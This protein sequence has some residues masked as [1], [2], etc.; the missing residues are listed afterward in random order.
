MKTVVQKG[1]FGESVFFSAPLRFAQKI[2][3][4]LRIEVSKSRSFFGD[5][6]GDENPLFGLLL[7]RKLR[8]A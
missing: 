5:N 8:L 1:V 4:N 7:D 6:K 2:S 3:E